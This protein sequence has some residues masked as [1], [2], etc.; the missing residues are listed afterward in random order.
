MA[1]NDY[2]YWNNVVS[3]IDYSVN[4]GLTGGVRGFVYKD[5]IFK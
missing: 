3:G 4:I 1:E 2:Q 5:G